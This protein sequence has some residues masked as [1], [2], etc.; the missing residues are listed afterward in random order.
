MKIDV[1][2]DVIDSPQNQLMFS[3][4]CR[5][6]ILRESSVCRPTTSDPLLEA[7]RANE[8]GLIA[9]GEF[10]RSRLLLCLL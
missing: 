6:N 3:P 9:P 2:I 10:V 5:G 4:L 8:G 1:T 7:S